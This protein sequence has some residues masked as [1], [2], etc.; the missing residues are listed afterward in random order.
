MS[1]SYRLVVIARDTSSRAA[2]LKVVSH[3]VV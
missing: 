1:K 2:R 3:Q